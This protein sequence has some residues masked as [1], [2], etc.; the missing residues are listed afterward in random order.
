MESV[1]KKY[2]LP[3]LLMLVFSM[4]C[5]AGDKAVVEAAETF[6][7]AVKAGD[8]VSMETLIG[9]PLSGQIENLLVNNA[10]YPDFLRAHY[11]GATAEVGE[12]NKFKG[13]KQVDLIITFADDRVSLIKLTMSRKKTGNWQVIE[14]REV[15]E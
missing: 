10:E 6:F 12:V 14:Q 11:E 4:P 5:A 3:L 1:M 13:D 8:V 15:I 7:E 2:I 9:A